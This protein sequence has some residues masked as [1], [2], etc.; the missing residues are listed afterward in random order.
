MEKG[1]HSSSAG[2]GFPSSTAL[3]HVAKAFSVKGRTALS[4]ATEVLNRDLLRFFGPSHGPDELVSHLK[5][6]IHKG[7]YHLEHLLGGWD[8]FW[9]SGGRRER[10]FRRWLPASLQPGRA[11]PPPTARAGLP[12]LPPA[13]AGLLPLPSA[14]ARL[15]PLLP[16]R[17]G[18]PPPARPAGLP[19]SC[20]PQVGLPPSCQYVR[21]SPHPAISGGPHPLLLA[22]AGLPPPVSPGGPPPHGTLGRPPP[23]PPDQAGLPSLLTDRRAGLP[24]RPARARLPP[25][26][27]ARE[28]LPPPARPAV[29]P[30]SCQP[31]VGLPPSCQS[32][33]ASPYP[34]I[35]GGPH[36]LLLAR[37]GLP[38]PISPGGPPPSRHPGQ[39]STPPASP[40]GPSLPPDRPAGR[41]SP[42]TSPGGP[43]PSC[44]PGRASPP[45]AGQGWPPPSR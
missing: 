6:L 18:V 22:R 23:L 12:P 41:P 39:A 5:F 15:P 33:R 3:W 24:L 29:L 21:A 27:P 43:P 16:A 28:G 2:Q 7:F 35:P 8:G 9:G 31:Q 42:P 26:P 38:P 37:A 45:P 14:R 32:V 17:E 11:S 30:L 40:G 20:Q 10:H 19:L 4:G 36:P 1:L 13:R 44:Q 25:L 34:A